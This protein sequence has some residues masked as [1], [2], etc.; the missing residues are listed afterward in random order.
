MPNTKH[1]L[2]C[3]IPSKCMS[4]GSAGRYYRLKPI[5][6]WASDASI[7]MLAF[8]IILNQI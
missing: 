7:G 1:D 6:F 5:L 3:V 2:S 8:F 4:E